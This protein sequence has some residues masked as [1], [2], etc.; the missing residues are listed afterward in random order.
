MGLL[1]EDPSTPGWMGTTQP[2]PE[3]Q[4]VPMHPWEVGCTYGS[5]EAPMGHG[6][7]PWEPGC[8]RE[9]QGTPLELGCTHRAGMHL[10]E[11]GYTHGSRDV[12]TGARMHP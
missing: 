6:M 8:T 1:L 2:L 7:Y 3:R 11:S 12:P 5:Q 9:S 4:A 10:W